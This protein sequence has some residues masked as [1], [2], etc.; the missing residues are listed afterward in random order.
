MKPLIALALIL[1]TLTGCETTE[2][3]QYQTLATVMVSVDAAMT[4]YGDAVRLGLVDTD[5]QRTVKHE[6]DQYKRLERA[7]S[8]QQLGLLASQLTLQI[9]QLLD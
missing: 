6:F 4:A 9:A 5:D 8:P 1:A 7:A 3:T 2:R